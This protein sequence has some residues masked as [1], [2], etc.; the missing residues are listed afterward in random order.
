MKSDFPGSS[1]ASFTL[2]GLKMTALSTG[3]DPDHLGWWYRVSLM[4]P[5]L[6]SKWHSHLAAKLE[7]SKWARCG[8]DRSLFASNQACFEHAVAAQIS[9]SATIYFTLVH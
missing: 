9:M 5:S 7:G 6:K 3:Q 4:P 1:T 2:A 8:V